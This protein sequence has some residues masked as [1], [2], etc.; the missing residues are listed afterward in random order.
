MRPVIALLALV[1]GVAQAAGFTYSPATDGSYKC[2][3]YCT[4]YTTS[5][6]A[7][8]VDYVNIAAAG[9]ITV[10]VDGA[11]YRAT[12]NIGDLAYPVLLTNSATGGYVT[13]TFQYTTKHTCVRS[14][15]GQH[16]TTFLYAYQGT[17][18]L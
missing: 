10:S 13:M 17:V 5:D 15:R 2:A 1:T 14:G 18:T 11:Y 12:Y 8:S 16:C 7:H 9:T 3:N 6:P 4:G